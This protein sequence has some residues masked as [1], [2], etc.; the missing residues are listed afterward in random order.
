[1]LLFRGEEHIDAW[2]TLWK[3]PRGGKLTLGQVKGLADYW[4]S[5]GSA[6]T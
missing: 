5:P 2:C 4:Y 1:M 3:Q 6:R